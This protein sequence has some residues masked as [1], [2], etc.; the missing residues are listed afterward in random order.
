M[1]S[2]LNSTCIRPNMPR[3]RTRA[4]LSHRPNWFDPAAVRTR[5]STADLAK[6]RHIPDIRPEIEAYEIAKMVG[7]LEPNERMDDARDR[8]F[9]S[10]SIR[11]G[12]TSLAVGSVG[13][14]GTRG[15]SLCCT[16][17]EG[18]DLREMG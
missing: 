16:G 14:G 7:V 3:A 15:R 13:A 18:S 8:R 9:P 5:S 6:I 17:V 12:V 11:R 2:T 10:T 1:R 4:Q